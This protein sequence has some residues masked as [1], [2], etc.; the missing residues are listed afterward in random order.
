MAYKP[1]RFQRSSPQPVQSVLQIF[2]ADIATKHPAQPQYGRF[3]KRSTAFSAFSI[4]INSGTVSYSINGVS[5]VWV[6][7]TPNDNFLS[8]HPSADAIHFDGFYIT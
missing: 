6:G 5:I 4:N 3:N 8:R 1:S 7:W 2:D